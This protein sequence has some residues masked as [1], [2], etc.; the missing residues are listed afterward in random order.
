MRALPRPCAA[1][2]VGASGAIG[3][4][5]ADRLEADGLLVHRLSRARDGFDITD[6]TS[7]VRGLE[8][9]PRDPP[10]RLVLVATGIL[11]E[12]P[13]LQPEKSLKAL[14]GP[15]L[16]RAYAVNAI[17][18]LL[19]AKH[20]VPR[21]PREGRVVVAA[22]S[23]R[24]GSIAD[25]RLGGWYG[26]RASKAALNQMLRTLAIELARQRPEAI[27]AALH[28]GT[29]ATDLSA[30]FRG[31]AAHVAAPREAAGHLLDVLDALTPADSGGLYA[32][33]GASIPF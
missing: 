2:V 30:P 14:A 11:H 9:L 7:I 25:N 12:G 33:D 16:A 13:D 28:P 20:A 27:V 1:L 22:L 18:P 24:V 26:Y 10:L 15:S 29:V 23:A 4:A 3:G 17:G 19:V 8:A 31:G 6:E 32:W 21:L 5:L